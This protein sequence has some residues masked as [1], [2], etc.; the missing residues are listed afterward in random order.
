MAKAKVSPLWY[1]VPVAFILAASAGV[2][3]TGRPI[4]AVASG[5]LLIA[6]W[7]R[8]CWLLGEPEQRRD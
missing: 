7:T 2:W 3:L 6:G 5:L 1:L 4:I 8:V